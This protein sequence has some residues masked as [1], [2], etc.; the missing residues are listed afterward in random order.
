MDRITTL[1][2]S[3]AEIFNIQADL[4]CHAP[5]RVNLMGDHTDYNNGF[6]LPVAINF[7]TDI[8][9]SKRDDRQ[10]KVV[11][12]DLDNSQVNFSL[13][14]IQFD[15]TDSWSNYVR[16]S[17]LALMKSFPDISGANLVVSGN[18]PQGAGLS[19]SASFEIAILS[20]F[21]QLYDLPLTGVDAALKGQQAE[22]DFVGCNCGIM[23][24]LISALGKKS[25]VMLL[26]SQDLTV[27]YAKIPEEFSI[28]I[29]NSNVKRGLVDSE[30]N[31]R[32]A[33][34]EQVAEYF[35]KSSL[36]AV[37]L[38]ELEKNKD[39]IGDVLYQR[40]H[41]VLSENSRTLDML[42][43]LNNQDMSAI[44]LVMEESHRSL[45]EDF[46][47]STNEVDILV[48]I[49]ADSLKDQGGVRMTGGGFGGCVVALAPK[50]LIPLAVDAVLAQYQNKTGLMPDIY[51]C[52][53]VDGAFIHLK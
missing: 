9:A 32:R 38:A 37:T 1:K 40:A 12:L 29:V 11:A 42:T 48:D 52:K 53:T 34:C 3:F 21:A 22:N 19:S 39:E 26:D 5:G 49:L 18:V 4:A 35:G 14:N 46:G 31:T 7:G 27:K 15:H 50:S 17:L 16:G 10:V 23:D 25:Q 43:A 45:K 36:R 41:H 51:Q 33:Q 44:S 8:A 20:A 2:Y 28:L 47:V 24:Q 30:Y 6:V 13:D